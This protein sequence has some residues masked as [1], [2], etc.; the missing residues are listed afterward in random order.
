MIK[1]Y[2]EI[3]ADSGIFTIFA[4]EYET[5]FLTVFPNIESESLDVY[6]LLNYGNRQLID[7][8]TNENKT[9]ICKAVISVNLDNWKKLATA[10]NTTLSISP[11]VETKTKTGTLQRTGTNTDTTL[12]ANKAFN[13]TEF[14]DND[15]TLLSGNSNTTDAYNL[16]ETTNGNTKHLIENIE[17]V[18]NLQKYNYIKNIIETFIN[19]IAIK[20][21]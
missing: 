13:D 14:V 3:F 8:F 5:D 18:L 6:T 7:V 11:A 15:K 20:I 4:T 9:T 10:A 17:S 19:E 2:K 21:Y 16:T 12:N 1:K